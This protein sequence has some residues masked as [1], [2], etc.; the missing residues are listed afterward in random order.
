M[1]VESWLSVAVYLSLHAEAGA[2][3]YTESV[4]GGRGDTLP[5]KASGAKY[6]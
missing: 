5:S 1:I 4:P 3:K 2:K 6:R